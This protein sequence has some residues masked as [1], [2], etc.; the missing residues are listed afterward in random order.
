MTDRQKPVDPKAVGQAFGQLVRDE[1][2][3]HRV[4]WVPSSSTDPAERQKDRDSLNNAL[5][6]AGGRVEDVEEDDG[7]EESPGSFPWRS[8]ASREGGT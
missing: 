6:R 1:H 4:H 8:L 5:R 3:R 7:P 2:S